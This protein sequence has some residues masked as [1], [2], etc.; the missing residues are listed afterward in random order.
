MAA[1]DDLIVACNWVATQLVN[2]V[3]DKQSGVAG[4]HQLGFRKPVGPTSDVVIA[5]DGQDWSDVLQRVNDL[6]LA[7][8]A[9]VDDE[10]HALER[11]EGL[12]SNQTVGIGNEADH[13]GIGPPFRSCARQHAIR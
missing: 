6:P 5:F 3:N 10:I 12:G 4:L 8:V 11:F 13:M 7:D 2:V 1:D 9:G